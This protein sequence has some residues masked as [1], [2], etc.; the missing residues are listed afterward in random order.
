MRELNLS[1]ER[2]A[3]TAVVVALATSACW[4][5]AICVTLLAKQSGVVPPELLAAGRALVRVAWLL[6]REAV[7]AALLAVFVCGVIGL[8]WAQKHEETARR[9]ARHA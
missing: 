8:A 3:W 5:A 1:R 2:M 6:F 9:G 4:L 7:P